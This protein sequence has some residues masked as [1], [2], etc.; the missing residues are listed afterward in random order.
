ME[1]I[2]NFLYDLAAIRRYGLIRHIKYLFDLKHT[3]VILQTHLDYVPDFNPIAGYEIKEVD[4]KDPIVLSDWIQVVNEA[5]SFEKPYDVES[6]LKYLENHPYKKLENLMLVYHKETHEPVGAYFIGHLR[7]NDQ[8]GTAGRIA[9][10]PSHQR[11][12]L[13]RMIALYGYERMRERGIQLTEEVFYLEKSHSISLFMNCGSLPQFNRKYMQFSPTR[14]SWIISMLARRKV[15]RLYNEH[16]AR[17]RRPFLGE[18][19]KDKAF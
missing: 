1:I 10:I 5:F 7:D 3:I 4:Y 9:I 12:G 2:S 8:I 11:K 6:A 16:L 15:V 18:G 19:S 13:G 17:L 14:K